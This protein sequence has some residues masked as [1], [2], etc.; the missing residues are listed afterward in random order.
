MNS[1]PEGFDLAAL[2][3][4]IL[5]EQPAG[6][7]QR[8]DYSP[9]S[10]YYRLRDA[11]AEARALERQSDASDETDKLPPQWAVVERLA[12]ETLTMASKDL[13]VAAWY[14]EALVRT[15]GLPGF[16]AGVKL[17]AGLAETYWDQL[18]PL[19]DQD[20]IATRVAPITGLNGEGGDGTLIQPL[21]KLTLYQR[22]TGERLALWEYQQSAD[23][24]SI[25]DEA[26][27]ER[28]SERVVAFDQI[29]SEARGT[30]APHFAIL[31]HLAVAA[32]EAWCNLST[33]LDARAG[34]DVPPMSRV[35]AI[36]EQL[37]EIAKKYAPPEPVVAAIDTTMVPTAAA[38]G[39]QQTQVSLHSQ[40][41][42]P[43][44]SREDALSL[45]TTVADFFRRTE[46][47]SPLAYTL[48]EAVRRA[49]LTWPKLLEEIVPDPAQRYPILASL[50]IRPP[51]GEESQ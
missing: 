10:L 21:R 45:L 25:A 50:G 41:A 17:M 29:E 24:L 36:L 13:E 14:T 22:P 48:D 2:L 26:R 27:R 39:T 7:D 30:A 4:P 44:A 35:G 18:Y 1:L 16:I 15:Q 42:G 5:G 9:Q 32:R 3:Q 33:V 6:C 23:L 43:I 46:P 37:E 40:P 20:G 38:A 34:V 28:L 11:R 31:S 51:D 19:P 8:G 47:H 12:A 49:R